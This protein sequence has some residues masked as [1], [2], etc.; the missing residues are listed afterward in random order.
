[1]AEKKINMKKM[2]EIV[3][4]S[5][6][7]V[8]LLTAVIIFVV[9]ND[10]KNINAP[11]NSEI[12]G[13]G[14]NIDVAGDSGNSGGESEHYYDELFEEDVMEI[15]ITMSEDDT[16]LMWETPSEDNL[17]LCNISIN[18]IPWRNVAI[19]V[20]GKKNT[21]AVF[22]SGSSKYSYKLD[23]N[24][25]DSKNEFY[26]LDG[27]YLYN[28]MEDSS[29]IGQYISYKL[30]EKLGGITPYYTLARVQI[31]N[32]EAEWYLV[33]EEF[34]NSFAK[35]ITGDDGN[36]CLFKAE[37]E[38][39]LLSES[40]NAYNYEVKYG[41]D[42]LESYIDKLVEVLNNP[43]S[44]ET[45]IEEVL[46]VDSVLRSLAVNYVVGNY[47]GYQGPDPDNF[48]LLYD[49]GIISYIDGSFEGAGGNY[50]KDLGY[51]LNVSINMP[52]YDTHDEER[53][54]VTVLLGKEEYYK[55]Y[56]EYVNQLFQYAESGEIITEAKELLGDYTSTDAYMA[57]EVQLFKYLYR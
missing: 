6:V 12:N 42:A 41:D 13:D 9:T 30:M 22:E 51:S 26:E 38:D 18:N 5:V 19:R 40:D 15:K 39:A 47:S 17:Y 4:I 29:Y 33:T 14:G 49:N 57:G 25:F 37:N 50:R 16:F 1:M 8:L 46:D 48:Y 28:M 11:V 32:G 55:K 27:L 53:P 7:S 23:F 21:E 36:V 34:N 3:I 43:D 2:R 31:N 35:R 56:E 20:R 44:T 54:L 45:D 10:D 24:E 52:L